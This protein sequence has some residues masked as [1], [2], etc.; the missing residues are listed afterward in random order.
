MFDQSSGI[1]YDTLLGSITKMTTHGVPKMHLEYLYN[2]LRKHYTIYFAML[3]ALLMYLC[4]SN[5]KS[6]VG[7]WL[8]LLRPKTQVKTSCCTLYFLHFDRESP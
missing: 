8:L 6:S 3:I 2:S 4:F 1:S 7:H 5:T